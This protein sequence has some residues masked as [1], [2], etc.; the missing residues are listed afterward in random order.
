MVK[1]CV[2]V[3]CDGI[4]VDMAAALPLHMVAPC[5]CSANRPKAN[6]E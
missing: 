1:V 2:V 6:V 4:Q 3:S 5:A